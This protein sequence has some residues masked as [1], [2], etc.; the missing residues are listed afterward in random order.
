MDQDKLSIYRKNQEEYYSKRVKE[1]GLSVQADGWTSEKL[2]N[3]FYEQMD[4]LFLREIEANK[5]F[6]ILDV[7]S[8]S[9]FYYQ[10]LK[11]KPWFNLI[12]YQG[13]EI[14]E[15]SYNEAKKM[16]PDTKYINDDFFTHNFAG[17]KF[18]FVISIGA[19]SVNDYLSP[20]EMEE[21]THKFLYKM[22]SLSKKAS[23][24]ASPDVLLG[25]DT[26]S[27][28]HIMPSTNLAQ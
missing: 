24:L 2:V 14:Y 7:G 20:E 6:S 28:F 27:K 4:G 3:S 10:Y 9:G 25:E 19:L 26:I 18:D 15:K 13:L 16:N 17:Q 5:N 12:D 1:Y 8:G 23:G 22:F 21:F 11:E